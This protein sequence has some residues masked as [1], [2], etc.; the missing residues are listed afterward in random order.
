MTPVPANLPAEATAVIRN[1]QVHSG[2]RKILE[3]VDF[4]LA[5][6]SLHVIMGASGSGKTTL[7]RSLNRLNELNGGLATTGDVFLR[8]GGNWKDIYRNGIELTDLRRRVGMV[9]QTPNVLPDSIARN[10]SLPLRH[11]RG[12]SRE[13]ITARSEEVLR[14]VQLWDEVRDRLRDSALKLSG[15]QQQRLCLARALALEP[16]FLLLDEPSASLDFRSTE[17]IEDLLLELRSRCQVVAV[18]HSLRQARKIADRLTILKQGRI[19][20]QLG[21]DE[22]EQEKTLKLLLQDVF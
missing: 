18:S 17:I 12:L 7:L 22:L 16:E 13:A 11:V 15:G 3:G 6:G 14:Q 8:L 19:V 1:L 21:K 4:G 2:Q 9:F 20:A 5:K 10:L